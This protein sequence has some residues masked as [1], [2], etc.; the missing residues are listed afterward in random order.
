[1]TASEKIAVLGGGTM[2]GGVAQVAL[3]AGYAVVLYDVSEVALERTRARIAGGLAR[4]GR[5]EVLD[6]LRCVGM[7]EHI[8]GAQIVVEAAPERLELKQALLHKAAEI[9][10]APA[11]LASNTSSLP[12]ASLAAVCS[13]PER[14]AGLHFFN[15]VHRMALVELVRAPRTD[16]ATVEA[17]RAFSTRIG[18]T[19]VQARDTP[20]FIVNR[21]ARPFYGEALRLLGDGAA[22]VVA[23]DSLL[24]RAG[25][26]PLGPFALMDLIGVDVNFAVT[27]SV[28]EQM[29][30]EPRFRP[31]RIQQQLVLEGALGRKSGRGFYD[32]R[33]AA[34]P[35]RPELAKAP[36]QGG[37]VLVSAGSW[38][39]MVGALCTDAG[40]HILP[41]QTA[42]PP[43]DL[44]AAFVIAGRGEGAAELVA[45]LDRLLDPTM[46]LFAQCVDTTATELAQRMQHPERLVGFDGLFTDG[47]LTLVA[48]S[49]LDQRVRGLAE[50]LAGSLG[51]VPI[52]VADTAALVVPRVVA[53]LANEAAFTLGEGVAEQ[54][55]IDTAMRLGMNHPLGPLARAERLGYT[56]V[57]AILDH[58]WA[59]LHEE[60][61]RVAPA[62]R[63]AARCGVLS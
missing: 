53:Q 15:P 22:G 9:C 4:Q 24:E 12:I 46:P 18:K 6:R 5:G 40:L 21:V 37:T 62:L 1:M 33:G 38:G 36:A 29:F 41:A 51:R 16:D 54:A 61:Y 45:K 2:G 3:A 48:T 59:E 30:H 57:V 32:Y 35:P 58:L 31:H 19:V 7:L 55:A 8:A 60:R 43:D 25:H 27:C 50:D 52:W 10:P 47:A 34:V 23:I 56:R 39:P 14:V 17:L 28:Y 20:G 63:Q 44:R 49:V 11:I 42:V 13:N 26:F